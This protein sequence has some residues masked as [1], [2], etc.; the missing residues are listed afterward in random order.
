MSP[1]ILLDLTGQERIA[2]LKHWP[3]SNEMTC[4]YLSLGYVRMVPII[5][6]SYECYSISRKANLPELNGVPH[7]RKIISS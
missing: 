2:S 6:I 5:S 1:G 7:L 4:Q 3:V